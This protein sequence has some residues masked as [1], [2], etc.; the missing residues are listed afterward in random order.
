MKRRIKIAALALLV[1]SSCV[2]TVTSTIAWFKYGNDISF[3]E[4]TDMCL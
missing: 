3:G 4:D 2:A 1:F